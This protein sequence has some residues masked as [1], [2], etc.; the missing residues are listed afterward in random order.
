M[1]SDYLRIKPA[2]GIFHF[3]NFNFCLSQL[4]LLSLSLL[5]LPQ[6]FFRLYNSHGLLPY[7]LSFLLFSSSDSLLIWFF[8]TC[9]SSIHHYHSTH[10]YALCSMTIPPPLPPN[11]SLTTVPHTIPSCKMTDFPSTSSDTNCHATDIVPD[12]PVPSIITNSP[13]PSSHSSSPPCSAASQPSSTSTTH[14]HSQSTTEL[15]PPSNPQEIPLNPAEESEKLSS[16][17]LTESCTG[18]FLAVV[19]YFF[20]FFFLFYFI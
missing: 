9:S 12:I 17:V 15:E 14:T 11:S 10:T 5:L 18:K 3:H 8:S 2:A 19:F 20:L 6:L 7:F 13:S 1:P 4:C 16:P